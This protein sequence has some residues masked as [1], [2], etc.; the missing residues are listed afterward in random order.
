LSAKAFEAVQSEAVK[1]HIPG[2]IGLPISMSPQQLA[3]LRTKIFLV[4]ASDY[5]AG[6]PRSLLPA[7]DS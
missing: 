3:Q 4:A 5:G 1:L 7:P 2:E 6:C